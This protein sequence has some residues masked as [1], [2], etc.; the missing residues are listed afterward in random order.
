MREE[1]FVKDYL[2]VVARAHPDRH[3]NDRGAGKERVW[4]NAGRAPGQ[5]RRRL[6]PRF[7]ALNERMARV[8]RAVKKYRF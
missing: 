2:T 8:R 3:L 7:P 4:K 6:K 1:A 5:R